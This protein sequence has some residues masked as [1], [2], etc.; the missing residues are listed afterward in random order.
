[1]QV[2][3]NVRRGDHQHW[4]LIVKDMSEYGKRKSLA[5]ILDQA[6]HSGPGMTQER[7]NEMLEDAIVLTKKK[8]RQYVEEKQI[9]H[10]DAGGNN[11]LFPFDDKTFKLGI[12]ELIDW[13]QWTR[14]VVGKHI[15][16]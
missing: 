2:K 3:Q 10:T 6:S 11:A 13:G 12:P 9:L 8:M 15:L 5:E 4:W 1:M 14:R 7:C 16:C